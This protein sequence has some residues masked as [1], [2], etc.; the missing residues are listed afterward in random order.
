MVGKTARR[1]RIFT[2]EEAPY[3]RAVDGIRRAIASETV[4]NRIFY[5]IKPSDGGQF[6]LPHDPLPEHRPHTYVPAGE[7]VEI[8]D[9]DATIDDDW[10]HAEGDLWCESAQYAAASGQDVRADGR[11]IERPSRSLAAEGS[12]SGHD[13]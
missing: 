10:G 11:G 2:L 4:Q 9:R 8:G 13:R 1:P 12:V 7:R 3:R 5:C 6:D